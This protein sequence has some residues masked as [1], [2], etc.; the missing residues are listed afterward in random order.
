MISA[1]LVSAI[2]SAPWPSLC[3]AAIAL[4]LFGLGGLVYGGTVIRRARRQTYY[5]PERADWVWYALLPGSAYA[6]VAVAALSLGAY[7]CPALFATGAAALALLLI[8]IHN[9]WDTVVHIVVVRLPSEA[10]E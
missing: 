7:P 2:M 9:A 10:R 3:S 8:G 6:A 5:K 4:T 1:L